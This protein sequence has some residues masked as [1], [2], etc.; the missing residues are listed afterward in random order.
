MG[1]DPIFDVLANRVRFE[2]A[3]SPVDLCYPASKA[4]TFG[5]LRPILEYITGFLIYRKVPRPGAIGT[6]LI[7][8]GS[9]TDSVCKGTYGSEFAAP[10]IQLLNSLVVAQGMVAP[11][12]DSNC[13]TTVWQIQRFSRES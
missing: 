5:S 9:D 11:V 1:L 10:R 13:F 4:P 3:I 8:Y 2:H 7:W 6:G 12:L